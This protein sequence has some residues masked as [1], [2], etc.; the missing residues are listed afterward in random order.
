MIGDGV[1]LQRDLLFLPAVG[2]LEFGRNR[3]ESTPGLQ[4]V[5]A[6]Q[7]RFVLVNRRSGGLDIFDARPTRWPY[8]RHVP[9]PVIDLLVVFWSASVCG[10]HRGCRRRLCAA[11]FVRVAVEG[12]QFGFETF[13]KT[14]WRKLGLPVRARLSEHAP[15][16]YDDQKVAL[17]PLRPAPVRVVC[18]SHA[19]C[20]N[21]GAAAVIDRR[22]VCRR[23]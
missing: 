5:H 9:D 4:K 18:Y 22:F 23:R 8:G 13:Q 1:S 2:F 17:R 10:G 15:W 12:Q 3:G 20:G 14:R 16:V 6:G 19:G 11:V 7:R 21:R